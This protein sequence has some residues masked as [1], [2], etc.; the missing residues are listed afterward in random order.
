[1]KKST[2]FLLSI[3][4]S[5]SSLAGDT[6][7]FRLSNPWNTVKDVNGKY[8]RKAVLTKDSSWLTL[9]Y[10][11]SN[12]LVARSYYTDTT[13]KRKLFCHSYFDEEKGYLSQVRCYDNGQLHGLQTGFASN[14][15]TLWTE[16]FDHSYLL[17]S[18]NN[19]GYTP[20][21]VTVNVTETE[22]QFPGGKAGWVKFLSENFVYPQK[23]VRKKIQG[24]V[25]V[26]FIVDKEGK[27]T[28]VSV[29][30]PIDP[31]LD[32]AAIELIKSSPDWIPA[33]QNGK[34]VKSYKKQPIVFQL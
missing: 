29:V 22:S 4:F 34:K 3:L 13:F 26:Q 23:A 14:G 15:D 10:N 12:I 11:Q 5:F 28:D 21:E 30:N 19:P 18:K 17:S 8:L 24:T 33:M 6:L 20:K 31:L 7:Y 9:D 25:V 1:M 2:V 27:V 16:T 32:A